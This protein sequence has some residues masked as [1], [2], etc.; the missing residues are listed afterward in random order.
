MAQSESRNRNLIA[1][2]RDHA[3][4]LGSMATSDRLPVNLNIIAQRLRVTAVEFQPLLVSAMLSTHPEGFRIFVKSEVDRVEDLRKRFESE[5]P[6]ALLPTKVRFSIAHEL[7]HALLYNLAGVGKSIPREK[8]NFRAG[9]G[10]TKLSILERQCDRIAGHLLMPSPIWEREIGSLK[11]VAP[12][13][14]LGLA[15][16]A[17]VSV[18]ALVIRLDECEDLFVDRYFKGCIAVVERFSDRIVVKSVARPRRLNIAKEL[19][20]VRSG[21]VWQVQRDDGTAAINGEECGEVDM[22]LTIE[23]R[24]SSEKV[25]HR[26]RFLRYSSF[27]QKQSYLL[28]V[29]VCK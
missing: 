21:E 17:G 15:R 29:A 22:L 12:E 13:E 27:E 1:K 4:A 26:L 28:S 3:D 24:L 19:R 25:K 8:R 18:E 2:L 9:G 16:R 23:T 14:L 20:F 5:A 7:A 10:K 11:S 6:K